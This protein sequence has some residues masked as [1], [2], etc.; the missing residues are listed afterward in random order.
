MPCCGDPLI[1][2]HRFKKKKKFSDPIFLS[3]LGQLSYKLS[4]ITFSS[5]FFGIFST[6]VHNAHTMQIG[7]QQK[8]IQ[9]GK[10]KSTR[11]N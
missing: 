4:E 5:Q 10:K 7:L 3:T 1:T 11:C 2:A 6:H 9:E 8:N